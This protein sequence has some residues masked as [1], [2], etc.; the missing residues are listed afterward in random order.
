M[1]SYSCA[2][3]SSTSF[4]TTAGAGGRVREQAVQRVWVLAVEA[5]VHRD[6]AQLRP[7]GHQVI[8]G[9]GDRAVPRT[10]L[11]VGRI[12]RA[13]LAVVALEVAKALPGGSQ[14]ER[15]RPPQR[16]CRPRGGDRHGRGGGAHVSLGVDRGDGEPVARGGGQVAIAARQAAH[17]AHHHPAAVDAVAGE[18]P[19]APRGR[20]RQPDLRVP[21]TRDP[22]PQRRAR[23]P[24][25]ADDPHRVALRA[26][27]AAGVGG[28]HPVDVRTSGAHLQRAAADTAVRAAVPVH[29]ISGHA[30]VAG[31]ARRPHQARAPLPRTGHPEPRRELRAVEPHR[32]PDPRS[33]TR[34]FSRRLDEPHGERVGAPGP[35]LDGDRPP[36]RF[37]D[38][39]LVAEHA[40]R[41]HP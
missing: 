5:R 7:A 11:V 31:L 3:V 34:Q 20:P 38:D 26:H 35:H 30:P 16:G 25:A 12:H 40:I 39:V 4:A 37:A 13:D 21:D 22:Q 6:A 27:V 1:P 8:V 2:R 24:M 32:P 14:Q 41:P 28:S 23:S 18:A 15:V 29:P 33:A 10:A 17:L 36:R 9:P 19:R